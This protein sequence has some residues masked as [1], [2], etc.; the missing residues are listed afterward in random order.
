MDPEAAASPLLLSRRAVVAGTLAAGALAACGR[1]TR[2]S[3]VVADLELHARHQLGEGFLRLEYRV[4]NLADAP[5]FLFNVL[6]RDFDAGVFPL[7][8]SGYV[9]IGPDTVTVSRKLFA[10]PPFTLV[11]KRNV[12]FMTRL[13]PGAVFS[14]QLHLA[15]PLVARNPYEAEAPEGGAPANRALIFELGYFIGAPGTEQLGTMFPTD[16]GPRPGFEAFGDDRQKLA[17][18]ERLGDVPVVVLGQH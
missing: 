13:A 3:A 9:E 11:E 12:P 18:T 10:V 6:H 2:A 8:P 14:E 5:A 15:T 7:D 16:A 4:R 17:R 1:A